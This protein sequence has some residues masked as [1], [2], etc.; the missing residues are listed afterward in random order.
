MLRENSHFNTAISPAEMRGIR[1]R[2]LRMALETFE[3]ESLANAFV[4]AEE[5]AN[6]IGSGNYERP[7]RPA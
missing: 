7:E 2:S 1:E 6:Y 3:T 4:I 5:I